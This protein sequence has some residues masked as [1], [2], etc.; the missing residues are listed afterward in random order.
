MKKMNKN[1]LIKIRSP[2]KKKKG[3]KKP[4]PTTSEITSIWTPTSLPTSRLPLLSV[5]GIAIFWN[6]KTLH[7]R[8]IYPAK[9]VAMSYV[10]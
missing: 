10:Q 4:P 3:A 7:Q 5:V 1:L 6:Y 2:R 8:C 9:W